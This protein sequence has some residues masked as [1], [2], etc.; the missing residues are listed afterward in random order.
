MFYSVSLA[1]FLFILPVVFVVAEALWFGGAAGGY[2]P[3]IGKWYTFWA[4]GV[5]LFAAGVMQTFRPRFTAEGIFKIKDPAAHGLVREIGF[6]NLTFGT[7]ALASLAVPSWTVPAA[8]A[9]G[10]YYGLAGAGHL[11][12]KDRNAKEQLA[13]VT[14]FFA[15][16]VLA[17]FVISSLR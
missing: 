12:K 2:M 1:L 9:G 7:L 14:D 16:A 13:M 3:L 6:G 17:A 15:F 4:A 10:L 5:R 8:L 11:L